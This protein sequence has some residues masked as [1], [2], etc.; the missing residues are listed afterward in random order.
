MF[1]IYSIKM[2]V[3][4]RLFCSS[5]SISIGYTISQGHATQHIREKKQQGAEI[6][7]DEAQH[8]TRDNHSRVIREQGQ[9]TRRVPTSTSGLCG[10]AECHSGRT[11]YI[12]WIR[13]TSALK[14]E[15]HR[16]I[17]FF[18]SS[19]TFRQLPCCKSPWILS[20]LLCIMGVHICASFLYVPTFSGFHKIL[21]FHQKPIQH[22]RLTWTF[23]IFASLLSKLHEY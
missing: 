20:E 7:D 4:L 19:A 22:E 8:H 10:A 21:E 11:P 6:I 15:L 16:H 9:A 1:S 2:V 12:I 3:N 14:Q 5:C 18:S 17:T 13:M 23:Y